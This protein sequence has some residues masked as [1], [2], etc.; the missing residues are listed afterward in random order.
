MMITLALL[1]VLTGYGALRLSQDYLRRSSTSFANA[2]R[3]WV[4]VNEAAQ[5]LLDQDI[6]ESVGR[7][8]VALMA[9]AGCGCY[10][11]GMLKGHYLPRFQF[12]RPQRVASLDQA[13]KQ[14]EEMSNDQRDLFSSLV[15]AVMVYDSFRNPLQG[16]LFRRLLKSYVKP[17]PPLSAKY[18]ANLA[19][20]SVLSNKG[21]IAI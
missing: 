14:V 16:W 4:G 11:R 1:A 9:T 15:A 18:E 7:V 8:I 2:E 6:P 5:K 19:A 10:V 13:F 20:M 12:R 17:Q 21:A 3:A